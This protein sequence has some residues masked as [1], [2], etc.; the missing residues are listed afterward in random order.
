MDSSDPDRI[1][2][3]ARLQVAQGCNA[4]RAGFVDRLRKPAHAQVPGRYLLRVVSAWGPAL[5]GVVYVHQ[6]TRPLLEVTRPS[7]LDFLTLNT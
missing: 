3:A 5:P 4:C 1:A 2:P 7:Q 6:Y